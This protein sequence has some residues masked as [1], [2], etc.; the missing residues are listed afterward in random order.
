MS[1]TL[2]PPKQQQTSENDVEMLESMVLSQTS[3]RSEDNEPTSQQ[4]SQ[5]ATVIDE[6]EISDKE[7]PEMINIRIFSEDVS[8]SEF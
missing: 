4:P 8:V 5:Q 2:V 1:T 3:Q 7:T 6:G